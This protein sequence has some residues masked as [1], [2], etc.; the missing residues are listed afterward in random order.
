MSW[1]NLSNWLSGDSRSREL[2]D[3]RQ[4][5]SEA[6]A[7]WRASPLADGLSDIV[8]GYMREAM[9][10]AD[11]LPAL[12]ILIA[13]ADATE[14]ILLAEDI[15]P[16]E[17]IWMAIENDVEVA[18]NFRQMLVRRKRWASNFDQMCAPV[19]NYIT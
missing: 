14:E 15:Q 13:L 7:L 16:A 19:Q 4:A 1:G 2:R 12:P 3:T 6:E 9:R 18:S 8:L 5:W 17:A 11:R 10:R